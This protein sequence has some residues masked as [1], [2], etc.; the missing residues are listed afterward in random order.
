[1]MGR[2]DRFRILSGSQQQ[3]KEEACQ[4]AAKAC[5]IFPLSIYFYDFGRILQEVGKPKEARLLFTEFLKRI[6]S[7]TLDPI[8][9]F[10]LNQRDVE[11][12]LR[13]AREVVQG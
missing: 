2:A 9:E 13:H 5:S 12:A 8:M 6:G 11:D 3:Y 10:T 4:A 7:E 1:M